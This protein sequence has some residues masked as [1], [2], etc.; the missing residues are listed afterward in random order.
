[1]FLSR[2][3]YR[4]LTLTTLSVGLVATASHPARAGFEWSPAAQSAPAPASVHPASDTVMSTTTIAPV[5]AVPPGNVDASPIDQGSPQ[6]S[7]QTS[8]GLTVLDSHPVRRAV[9]DAMPAIGRNANPAH[10]T[11]MPGASAPQGLAQDDMGEPTPPPPEVSHPVRH[12]KIAKKPTANAALAPA[13]GGYAPSGDPLAGM[14]EGSGTAAPRPPMAQPMT[15]PAPVTAAAPHA[16]TP[17]SA[18][19]VKG[20]GRDMP[21]AMTLRQV[22]PAGYTWSFAPGVDPAAKTTWNGGQPWRET[23]DNTLAARNLVAD[24]QGHSIR[25]S[26][27][28]GALALPPPTTA[29][30][31]GNS[32]DPEPSYGH[33]EKPDAPRRMTTAAT[34]IPAGTSPSEA[35]PP[36]G[37]N[38]RPIFPTGTLAAGA[39]SAQNDGPAIAPMTS[40]A[41]PAQAAIPATPAAAPVAPPADGSYPRHIPRP[42]GDGNTTSSATTKPMPV[43]A[44]APAAVPITVAKA[45]PPAAPMPTS[46]PSP[47]V[48]HAVMPPAAQ[49]AAVAP[50]SGE[51]IASADDAADHPGQS[52]ALQRSGA[53]STHVDEDSDPAPATATFFG[54]T[55]SERYST[56]DAAAPSGSAPA[57]STPAPAAS[58]APAATAARPVIAATARPEIKPDTMPAPPAMPAKP[59]EAKALP[60]TTTVPAPMATPY[61]TVTA[62]PKKHYLPPPPDQ[63]DTPAAAAVAPTGAND[64]LVKQAYATLDRTAPAPEATLVDEH[65]F[66]AKAG[67]NLKTVLSQWC[68]KAGVQLAWNSGKDY[69][70]TQPVHVSGTFGEAVRQAMAQFDGQADRPKGTIGADSDGALRYKVT[71][72]AT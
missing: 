44:A 11:P 72:G 65:G 62:S 37:Y 51:V 66:N 42:Q 60:A 38:D 32:G 3:S 21:L 20:F 14:G 1:M 25:I 45:D 30:A 2:R 55:M 67:E 7:S 52:L 48:P 35:L 69:A 57:M 64:P 46:A 17:A 47:I 6:V 33:R 5:A 15:K 13:S 29:A 61:A 41:A 31:T 8:H 54:K 63:A 27:A 49:A 58:I 24:V 10:M 26:K 22:V 40:A 43:A 59:V 36:P 4:A 56:G 19:V 9:P 18:G 34:A 16:D 68:A 39:I 12:A 53:I 70:L 23:L 28:G 71:D 50:A